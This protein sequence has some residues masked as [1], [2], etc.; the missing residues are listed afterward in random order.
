MTSR[1]EGTEG[2]QDRPVL[3]VTTSW[4][5]GYPLDLR[6]AEL[7]YRYGVQGT[8][9]VPMRSP[10]PVMAPS[11]LRELAARFEIGGHTISHVLLDQ[12]SAQSARTEILE[13][14]QRLEDLT[15]APCL[16]FCPP[17]GRFGRAHLR[18][19]REAG[20]VGLRTVELMS[21]AY[22][23]SREGLVL[24]APTLQ[25]YQHSIST[26]LK[27]SCKRGRW[28]NLQTYFCHARGRDLAQTAAALLEKLVETGGV[29]HLWGHSW[30]LEH[31][32]LWGAL[33]DILIQLWAYRDRCRFVSNA[34]LCRR[35]APAANP[36][37]AEALR[38]RV[39]KCANYIV[40]QARN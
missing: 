37:P 15:G 10:M 24:L 12:V 14:K 31:S 32:R 1:P 16:T 2:P 17:G 21:V 39:E 33:E 29:F 22:P 27:N 25:L 9:Y 28:K 7:L 8:F 30:E 18:D 13:S 4:D 40:N 34:A 26:Y 20:Y 6:L 19:I 11:Q 5:D 38:G 35:F 36:G 3:W 23:R